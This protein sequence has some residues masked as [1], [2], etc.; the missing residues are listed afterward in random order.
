MRQQQKQSEPILEVMQK[1]LRRIVYRQPNGAGGFL[2][3]ERSELTDHSRPMPPTDDYH[4]FFTLKAFWRSFTA[5]LSDEAMNKRQV[6]HEETHDWVNLKPVM[7]HPEMETTI[8]R[9]LKAV[10]QRLQHTEAFLQW[11][12]QTAVDTHDLEPTQTFRHAV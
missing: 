12:E 8:A 2:Y 9:A 10:P 7:V 6:W 1:G 11:K 4:V 5:Y 3:L